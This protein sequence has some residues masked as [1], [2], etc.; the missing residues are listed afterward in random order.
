MKQKEPTHELRPLEQTMIRF[1]IPV[2]RE[3]WIKIA[4]SGHPPEDWTREL[5]SEL[6]EHL[7][8]QDMGEHPKAL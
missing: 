2:T 7:Q 5:E 6:P 8:R 1:G 3:N 4:Y